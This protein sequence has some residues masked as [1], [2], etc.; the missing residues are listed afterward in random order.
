MND[1]QRLLLL[2]QLEPSSKRVA[3]AARGWP[4]ASSNPGIKRLI[5][6]T[7]RRTS[8]GCC[9]QQ[10][11]RRRL[12]DVDV[13]VIPRSSGDGVELTEQTVCAD[14]R[15]HAV[16]LE[17]VDAAP[18]GVVVAVEVGTTTGGGSPVMVQWTTSAC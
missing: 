1:N 16:R 6:A 8:A 15:R 14:A 13:I 10:T 2:K 3:H 5:V 7:G 11:G 9:I 4:P 17:V 12:I 18:A